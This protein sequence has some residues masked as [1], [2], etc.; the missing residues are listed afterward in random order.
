MHIVLKCQFYIIDSTAQLVYP[1]GLESIHI[2][3]NGLELNK[4]QIAITVNI[5]DST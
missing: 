1:R 5:V 2:N 3:K 4:T